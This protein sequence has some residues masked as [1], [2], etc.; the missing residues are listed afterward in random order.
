MCRVRK[1]THVKILGKGKIITE[2]RIFSHRINFPI[3]EKKVQSRRGKL[4]L[5]FCKKVFKQKKYFFP[6]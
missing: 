5:L 4:T 1:I 3:Y 2:F 6:W